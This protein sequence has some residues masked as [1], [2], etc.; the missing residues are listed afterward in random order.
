MSVA[1]IIYIHGFNSSASSTKARQLRA[2]WGQLGLPAENLLT[3]D[4]PRSFAGAVAELEVLVKQQPTAL[5]VG[6]S[7]GGFY[8]TYLHHFYGNHG[9]LINP[10][11]G[12]H[13]RFAHYVGE[14]KNYHTGE[15]WYLTAAQVTELQ[16]IA[17]PPPQSGE[18]LQVWLQT[19]DETLDYRVA[20]D[21]YQDC[22]VEVEQG[23]DHAYQGFV[24]KIP[25]ILRLAGVPAT[26]LDAQHI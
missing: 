6:S 4:L 22:L 11:V 26:L 8:A 3:P 10:A 20:V 18:R 16:P 13:Q 14:Q 15:S 19:G 21:Y 23:G 17:V 1:S 24:E 5:L 2:A 9:L 7:L 25:Y 12:A